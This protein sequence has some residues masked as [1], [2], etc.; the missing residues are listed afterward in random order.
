MERE[1]CL[2]RIYPAELVYDEKGNRGRRRTQS[3]TYA[4]VNTAGNRVLMW[5]N[6][7]RRN[8][9][10][11]KKEEDIPDSLS[12]V[13]MIFTYG[14]QA[15]DLVR[16]EA[17]ARNVE[18]QVPE[19]FACNPVLLPDKHAM[20]IFMG[21]DGDRSLG[22]LSGMS[23]TLGNIEDNGITGYAQIQIKYINFWPD[24]PR[25]EESCFLF[26][27]KGDL[28]LPRLD[29]V[30]STLCRG[31]AAAVSWDIYGAGQAALLPDGEDALDN[32]QLLKTINEDCQLRLTASQGEKN[33]ELL[34]NVY[35]GLPSILKFSL[36]KKEGDTWEGGWQAAAYDR[37]LINGEEQTEAE[38]TFTFTSADKRVSSVLTLE[39]SI[40]NITRTILAPY[41]LKDG[42]TVESLQKTVKD[43]KD[44]GYKQITAAFSIRGA[45]SAELTE[46][47][48]EDIQ[49]SFPAD[50]TG[51]LKGEW[52]QLIERNKSDSIT[53][54]VKRKEGGPDERETI[55][56]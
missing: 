51:L 32:K 20:Q 31:K 2:T 38:G 15:A 12:V 28:I 18:I 46:N 7:T 50:E 39:G 13:V 35:I 27:R 6:S 3:F 25:T 56:I 48:E 21:A 29:I 17:D 37:L 43:F 53:L 34:R 14:D 26:K 5:K 55:A 44:R 49:K 23:C 52:R 16:T 4:M 54:T 41:E 22:P 33:R 10:E 9:E 47:P 30:P 42:L 19:G 45:A 40:C 8:I 36:E 11:I 1:N 24:I